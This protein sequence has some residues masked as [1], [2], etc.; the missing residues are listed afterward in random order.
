MRPSFFSLFKRGKY[1]HAAPLPSNDE[2]LIRVR[3][4]TREAERF[5]AAAIAFAWQ[6][7]SP[8]REHIWRTICHFPGDP[9][10]SSKATIAIEPH[11]WA[12]LLIVNPVKDGRF[13]Y[14]IE[15]KIGAPVDK[16][17]DP[18][19]R[20]FG[21]SGGYGR[22]LTESDSRIG[23]KFRFVIFG[24]SDQLDPNKKPWALPLK[25]EQRAWDNFAVQFPTTAFAR[26]LALSL[27]KLGVRAFSASETKTMKVNTSRQDIGNVIR[28]LAEVQ[29]QLDW[30]SGRGSSATFYHD[31]T[32]WFLGV[33]LMQAPKSA[34]SNSLKK[35]V[36]PP[37]RWQLWIGYEGEEGDGRTKLAFYI[38]C[39][40]TPDQEKI[41]KRLREK[42]KGKLRDFRIKTEDRD[43]N[44]FN[45][46]VK[47]DS[48]SLE[49]D[50][51]WFCLVCK[52]LDLKLRD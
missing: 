11:D 35:F 45:V 40:N 32:R 50:V 43:K 13:V 18:T 51:R 34:N 6:H 26:D 46:T 1:F 5:A 21:S 24:L 7:H 19:R 36:K 42:L 44:Y 22:F 10:L 47:A 3:G 49:S 4:N 14:V 30:P 48:N 23:T 39:G 20:A 12:D 28:T 33:D 15:C 52:A 25:V 38:Y 29:R 27:G 31:E 37:A 17:Q 41:A 16:H 2:K 9:P 8:L